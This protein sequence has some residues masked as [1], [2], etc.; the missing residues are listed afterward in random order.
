[1]WQLIRLK[2]R[3]LRTEK[4]NLGLTRRFLDFIRER[5][6]AH[7]ERGTP[8]LTADHLCAYLSYLVV[9]VRVS[10]STQEQALNAP[11]VL[12]KNKLNIK[13]EGMSSV[14]RAKR[15]SEIGFQSR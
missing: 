7:I 9:I 11:L 8:V 12:F 15:K 5:K 13:I 6:L 4:T 14:L 3:A 2:H 1:M 10:A